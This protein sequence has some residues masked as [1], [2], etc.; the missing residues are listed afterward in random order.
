M[1]WQPSPYTIPLAIAAGIALTM[2]V[3]AVTQRGRKGAVTMMALFGAM[4]LYA[5]GY[6]LQLTTMGRGF[7]LLFY[8]VQLLGPAFVTLAFF[9][10]ALQY[11]GRGSLVTPSLV[12]VFAA[13][14]VLTAGLVWTDVYGFH[15]L[16]LASATVQEVAGLQQLVETPGPWYAVHALYSIALTVVAIA[17]FT[18]HWWNSTGAD[19]K[20]SRIFAL[21]GLIPVA[22]TVAHVA[23][24]TAIDWGP[25]TYVV[26]GLMLIFAIF[27][28]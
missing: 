3:L 11:T 1:A 16:V 5:G 15:N 26:T 19:S 17:L 2:F 13:V 14:P 6:A 10:F 12:A 4:T 25:V 27:Y 8:A 28:Y 18:A 22:G 23:N 24:Y 7:K 9:I 20:R 21:S